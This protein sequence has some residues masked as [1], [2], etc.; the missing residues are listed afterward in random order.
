MK[1]LTILIFSTLISFNSSGKELDGLFGIT[2]NDNAEKYVTS[3]YINSNKLKHNETIDGF[4]SLIMTDK[5]KKES[6]Y[7]SN[8][9]VTLDN[10]NKVHRVTGHESF[11]NLTIC[12]AVRKDL[13]SRLEEKYNIDFEY[14]E[15]S[16]SDFKIYSGYHFN[17][18]G[19]AFAIQCNESY[20]DGDVVLQ[21]FIR[22]KV[23][24]DAVFEYYDSGL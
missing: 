5:I 4:F 20:S 22:S 18:S 19:D 12:Q 7:V 17:S 23:L 1:K 14:F 15:E 9:W 13:S 2:L 24:S 11:D 10:A 3:N 16:Y 6:P 8:Y 21:I